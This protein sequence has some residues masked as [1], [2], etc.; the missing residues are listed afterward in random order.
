MALG[1]GIALSEVLCGKDAKSW[2]KR[3][4]VCAG[5]NGCNNKN[6]LRRVSTLLQGHAWAVFDSLTDE[7]TDTYAHLKEALLQQLCP[8]TYEERLIMMSCH[9]EGSKKVKRVLMNWQLTM[10]NF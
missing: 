2:F 3:F 7:E 9:I 10:K 8:D 1:T 4:E 6:K 5:V